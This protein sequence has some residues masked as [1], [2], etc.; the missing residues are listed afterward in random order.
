MPQHL[1]YFRC[2]SR[3]CP[4]GWVP[5]HPAAAALGA[6]RQVKGTPFIR[7]HLCFCRCLCTSLHIWTTPV[8][9]GIKA[10]CAQV[11]ALNTWHQPE[12]GAFAL[13]V[14]NKNI[15]TPLIIFLAFRHL[16]PACNMSFAQPSLTHGSPANDCNWYPVK[17]S[18]IQKATVLQPWFAQ[19]R[20]KIPVN[21]VYLPLM[22]VPD[23]ETRTFDFLP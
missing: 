20:T 10:G 7:G 8:W 21:L 22:F 16:A 5:I 6:W 13:V 12:A 17:I 2:S 19:Y 15:G 3:L 18:H 9:P 11:S 4:A 23:T 1:S 14:L